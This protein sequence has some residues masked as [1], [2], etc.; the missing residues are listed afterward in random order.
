[1]EQSVRLYNQLTDETASIDYIIYEVGYED[2]L[3]N[4][5]SLELINQ[6]DDPLD[7][8]MIFH[9]NQKYFLDGKNVETVYDQIKS[10]DKGGIV[11]KHNQTQ[12]IM[13][14]EF[15][16]AVIQCQHVLYLSR[17]PD[18][19]KCYKIVIDNKIKNIL[20]LHFDHEDR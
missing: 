5:E 8:L 9:D 12:S 10:W 19:I 7:I 3:M 11:I 18:R 4:T 20:Y 17:S 14:E 13:I 6:F 2:R 16:D 1:M 15:I